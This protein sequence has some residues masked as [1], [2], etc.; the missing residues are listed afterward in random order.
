MTNLEE[1]IRQIECGLLPIE[2]GKIT[3]FVKMSPAL[4]KAMLERMAEY[5]KASDE[6]LK[7]I[8][9]KNENH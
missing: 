9:G 6:I 5:R 3:K 1:V 4:Q 2:D 8:L 7:A